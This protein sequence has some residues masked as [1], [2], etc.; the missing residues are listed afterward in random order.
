MPDNLDQWVAYLAAREAGYTGRFVQFRSASASGKVF[1]PGTGQ[2]V[3]SLP[4]SSGLG[5][6]DEVEDVINA[7]DELD[8]VEEV[9]NAGEN[10]DE[11]EDVINAADELDE[12]EEVV[13]A[14]DNLD[15]VEDVINAADELDEVEEVVNAGDNL[16]KAEDVVRASDEVVS[17]GVGG[18]HPTWQD[19]TYNDLEGPWAAAQMSWDV[20]KGVIASAWLD[21]NGGAPVND[22]GGIW[23]VLSNL[24]TDTSAV[25]EEAARQES[26]GN[27]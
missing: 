20:L 11:A 4:A 12:V 19:I 16:D 21:A 23:G 15:E 14:G 6:V 13:N 18:E 7:A 8:E 17:D 5:T 9:V 3:E 26:A 24:M 2:M 25:D 27:Q 22:V 10:L 1:D